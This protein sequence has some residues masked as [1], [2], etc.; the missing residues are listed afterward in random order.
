M[1]NLAKE[2]NIIILVGI[3]SLSQKIRDFDLNKGGKLAKMDKEK[4]LEKIE[5]VKKY[6]TPYYYFILAT[7]ETKMKD[8]IDNLKYIKTLP[9][10]WYEINIYI[11]P[12]KETNYFQKFQKTKYLVWR[13]R[14]SDYYPKVPQYL[15]CKSKSVEKLVEK[16]IRNASR[17]KRRNSRLSY[18]NLLLNELFIQTKVN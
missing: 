17:K 3:E 11:T 16:S 7:P 10:G 12:F 14:K 6:V 18:T 8:L 13:K 1:L 15:R 2:V 4:L 5:E 9:R